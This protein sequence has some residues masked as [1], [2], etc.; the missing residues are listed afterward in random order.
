[1]IVVE[2]R[3]GASKEQQAAASERKRRFVEAYMATANATEAARQAGYQGNSK[4]LNE[5]ARK[6]LRRAD[7]KAMLA[8]RVAADPKVATREERQRFWTE[9]MLGVPQLENVK[10]KARKV[11]PALKD[12][13]RA[14]ELL[15][16]SQGDFIEVKKVE[17]GGEVRFIVEIPDNGR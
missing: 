2:A 11:V 6:L 14:S 17:H 7:V 15:G 9:T 10:G 4:V 3:V 12:R 13:L 5:Q 1:M 8:K 16:K